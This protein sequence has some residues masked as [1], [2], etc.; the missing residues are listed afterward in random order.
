[1]SF[2]LSI[3]CFSLKG[4]IPRHECLKKISES[5]LTLHVGE[6]I[7]YPTISF[8]V[9]DYLSMR[10]KIVYLGRMD[11]F[12]ARFLK[13]NDLGFTIPVNEHELGV[14]KFISLIDR[15]A[16]NQINL[17]VDPKQLSNYTWDNLTPKLI[18]IFNKF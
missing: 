2:I 7:D 14:K 10:K 13:E 12:T 15:W 17:E 18:D 9:W 6:N 5:T 11:S 16:S 1:M 8:K 4:F 3:F